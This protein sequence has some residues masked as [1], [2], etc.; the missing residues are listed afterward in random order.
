MQKATWGASSMMFYSAF[1][2]HPYRDT[3]SC[4]APAARVVLQVPRQQLTFKED[5]KP[6]PGEQRNHSWQNGW[7]H[8]TLSTA[9]PLF[10]I[11]SVLLTPTYLQPLP[12]R[13][14]AGWV[15]TKCTHIYQQRALDP[16]TPPFKTGTL[17]ECPVIKT[18][19]CLNLEH[20][21]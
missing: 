17:H 18:G 15:W 13:S 7:K 11:Q 6:K 5:C 10:L 21:N 19:A 3:S 1:S 20:T 16:S 8:N 2:V 4:P 14:A 9:S 12:L